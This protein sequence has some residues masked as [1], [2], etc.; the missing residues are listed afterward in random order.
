[1]L[2]TQFAHARP[3]DDTAQGD[4][5]FSP[6]PRPVEVSP[7]LLRNDMQMANKGALNKMTYTS[8]ST[9]AYLNVTVSSVQKLTHF[10]RFR[11][12]VA[13]GRCASGGGY[14]VPV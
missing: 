13:R 4:N 1:M 14:H 10:D 7:C 6:K 11:A 3:A 8:L 9:I 12:L 5:L 2:L